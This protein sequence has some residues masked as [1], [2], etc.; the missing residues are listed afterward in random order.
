MPTVAGESG[1]TVVIVGPGVWIVIVKSFNALRSCPS[2][3]CSVKLN[4]PACVGMPLK[5]TEELEG[6]PRLIPGGG[7]PCTMLH[8]KLGAPFDTVKLVS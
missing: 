3:T 8:E 5:D 2:N 4:V 6:V 1:E 7:V